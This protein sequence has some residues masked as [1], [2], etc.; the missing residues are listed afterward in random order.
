[1]PAPFG[2]NAQHYFNLQ[3]IYIS[4]NIHRAPSLMFGSIK[5]QGFFFSPHKG[6]R[7]GGAKYGINLEKKKSAAGCKEVQKGGGGVHLPA[8]S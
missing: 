6:G 3:Y 8:G 7:M 5:M 1:M 4:L 2:Q